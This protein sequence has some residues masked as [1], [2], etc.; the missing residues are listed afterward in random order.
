MPARSLRVS[1]SIS[2]LVRMYA[3]SFLDADLVWRWTAFFGSGAMGGCEVTHA[4][5]SNVGLAYSK[6]GRRGGAWSPC[7]EAAGAEVFSSWPCRMRCWSWKSLW[8]SVPAASV[9]RRLGVATVPASCPFSS[10]I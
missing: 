9:R 1:S 4:M 8:K 5:V 6:D 3:A 10:R 7:W 2:A